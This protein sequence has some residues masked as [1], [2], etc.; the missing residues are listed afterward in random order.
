M[1]HQFLVHFVGWVGSVLL[2]LRSIAS[3]LSTV[4]VVKIGYR[5]TIF[6]GILTCSCSLMISSFIQDL[7]WYFV[8][9]S[10]MCGVGMSLSTFCAYDYLMSYFHKQFIRGS[11]MMALAS[12]L[13]KTSVFYVVY[14]SL[15]LLP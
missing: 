11:G 15:I 8:T 5:T 3:P 1:K 9:L 10:L 12:S 2:T 13:G 14:S 7:R 6:L 4:V